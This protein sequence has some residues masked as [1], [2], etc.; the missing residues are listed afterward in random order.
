MIVTVAL[1]RAALTRADFNHDLHVMVSA[2]WD[3]W[4]DPLASTI[5]LGHFKP[6]EPEHPDLPPV[7]HL[8]HDPS[9]GPAV[10][11]LT[12]TELNQATDDDISKAPTVAQLIKSLACVEL[13]DPALPVVIPAD[14]TAPTRRYA[15]VAPFLDHGYYDPGAEHHNG[16][17]G[18]D[19]TDG[20]TVHV[21][22]PIHPDRAARPL[23]PIQPTIWR[24][25]LQQTGYWTDPYGDQKP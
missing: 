7:G 22:W 6:V 15:P 3:E 18:Y 16:I 5:R 25:R 19:M 4:A 13:L 9:D 17:W 24:T 14:R 23:A 8:T 11:A 1:L 20:E 12:T 2:A 21:L 10:A